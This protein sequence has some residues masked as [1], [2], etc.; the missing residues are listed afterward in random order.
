MDDSWTSN[1]FLFSFRGR[2]NRA[3]YLYALFASSTACLV[4]LAMLAF[5]IGRILGV[6]VKSVD[7]DILDFLATRASWPFGVGF[8]DA[9]P[10]AV[11]TFLF[12][13]AGTPIFVVSMWFLAAAT[14]KR[15]HDR[16]KNGWWIVPWFVAPGLFDSLSSWFDD[17]TASLGA[18]TIGFGLSVW[19]FVEMIC[20]KGTS[21]PN[22]FGPD[23]LAPVSPD[24]PATSHRDQLRE[25]EFVPHGAGPAPGA[26]VK[27]GHD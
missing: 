14:I 16:N 25:L 23:P 13:L 12:Y 27:R 22:R 4:F 1:K 19:C 3:K 8:R 11:A 20:L 2:I 18:S 10:T 15:L 21:G 26:H 24:P 7:V 9:G 5:V 17:P 6:S